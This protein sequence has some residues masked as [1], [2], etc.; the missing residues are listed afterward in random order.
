MKYN[1][2]TAVFLAVSAVALSA[3]GQAQEVQEA[4][5]IRIEVEPVSGGTV[6]VALYGDAESWDEDR[7]IDTLSIA[8]ES[9]RAVAEFNGLP[10]GEYA[11]RF[12]H[13]ANGDDAF[14]TN[15]LGIPSEAYGF[16]NGARPSFR[17]ARWDEA[18]FELSAGAGYAEKIRPMGG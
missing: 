17:A 8:P 15:L 7:P 11:V 2:F 9:G 10:A 1:V 12:F 18:V 3:P 13:D 16:S 4:Q 6:I 5:P 14:N